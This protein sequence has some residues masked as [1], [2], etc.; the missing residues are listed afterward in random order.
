MKWEEQIASEFLTRR[1]GKEPVYEPLGKS[2][3]P[4]FSID[5][6][7]FEVRRLNQRFF[8]Q[9]RANEG[10]E[11]VEI[12]LIRE[13]HRELSRILFSDA[14]GTVFWGL[15]FGR[16]LLGKIGSIVKQ[17]AEE[18]R[19]YYEE[20]SGT[21]REITANGVTLDL[22]RASSSTRNAFMMGYTVDDDSGGMLGDIYP[23]SIR[24]ALEEKI[25]KTKRIADRFDRWVLILVDN[26]LP[27]MMEPI[28]VGPLHLSLAHFRS[29]VILDPTNTS[30]VLEHPDGSLKLH[31]HIR[32]RAYEF[33]EQRGSQHGH[34]LDDWLKAEAEPS[35]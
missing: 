30:L 17:L 29:L 20:G 14:G 27:G 23:T 21:P 34:D 6:T 9:D 22:F 35:S 3:P 31:P 7:A 5:E 33:Y 1:F 28:D 10:L 13:L 11:Q 26:V 4:D 24:L 15:K 12:P 2:N 16:P 8:R 32:Q 19:E 25:A 18:A